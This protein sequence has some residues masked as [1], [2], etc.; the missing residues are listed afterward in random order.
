MSKIIQKNWDTEMETNRTVFLFGFTS[1]FQMQRIRTLANFFEIFPEDL[2][3]LHVVFLNFQS[4]TQ[5]QSHSQ[6]NP[7]SNIPHRTPQQKEP[8]TQMPPPPP[9][10]PP[11]LSPLCP[12][13]QYIYPVEARIPNSPC[14][15]LDRNPSQR[16]NRATSQCVP[17]DPSTL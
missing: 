1:F 9:P 2:S 6:Q 13:C 8:K 10:P 15:K 4:I 11:L 14:K 7:S 16:R 3:K 17:A 5:G 12:R